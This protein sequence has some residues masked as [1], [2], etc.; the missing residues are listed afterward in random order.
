MP[1]R[2]L[3]AGLQLLHLAN[4]E[5]EAQR[6]QVFCKDHIAGRLKFELR[7]VQGLLWFYLFLDWEWSSAQP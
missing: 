3:K 2:H 4:A 7:S 5:K 6:R 1:Q